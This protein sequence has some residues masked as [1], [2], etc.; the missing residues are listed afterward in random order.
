M[1]TPAQESEA[2]PVVDPT[3]AAL[4]AASSTQRQDRRLQAQLSDSSG[5]HDPPRVLEYSPKKGVQPGS[6]TDFGSAPRGRDGGASY[7]T[8]GTGSV[9]GGGAGASGIAHASVASRGGA[10]SADVHT[11][12]ASHV[13]GSARETFSTRGSVKSNTIRTPHRTPGVPVDASMRSRRTASTPTT[14]TSDAERRSS[15]GPRSPSP[16]RSSGASAFARAALAKAR[17]GSPFST[18]PPAIV[19]ADKIRVREREAGVSCISV[20]GRGEWWLCRL[21]KARLSRTLRNTVKNL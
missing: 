19:V 17:L 14:T 11:P 13:G 10:D 6:R 21:R 9:R 18:P 4:G 7:S 15:A 16:L 5:G 20:D 8:R 12:T 1:F 2:A 3:V